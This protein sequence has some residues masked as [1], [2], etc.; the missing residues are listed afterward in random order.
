MSMVP[1]PPPATGAWALWLAWA[2]FAFVLG[3]IPV[4]LLLGRA[5]GI[6]LRRH[7]SGNIGATNALRV[8]GWKLG[9]LCFALD[10]LKGALPTLLAGWERGVLGESRIAPADAWGWMLVMAAPVI[11]HMFC[12]WLRCRGGKGVATSLGAMLGVWPALGLPALAALAVWILLAI[13]TRY[14]GISSVAA[15]VTLPLVAMARFAWLDAFAEGTPF[16]VVALALAVLVI[17]RHSGNIAR[18]IAGTERKLGER[19]PVERGGHAPP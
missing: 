14:V 17:A 7:G 8:L 9:M 13:A 18:T 19:A 5:R 11:G 16:I 15:A 4:G 10:V 6:D 12:P 3:S 1:P 2:L